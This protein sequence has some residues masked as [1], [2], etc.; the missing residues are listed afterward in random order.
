MRRVPAGDLSGFPARFP[1][2]EGGDRNAH[3]MIRA[4][5]IAA[6]VVS[7]CMLA[8]PRPAGAVACAGANR[9]ASAMSRAAVARALRCVVAAERAQHGLPAW[10][11]NRRLARAAR[12][13]ARDMVRRRYFGHASPG[14]EN[15]LR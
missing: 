4:G 15:V 3:T 10:Q 5:T 8:A 11:P 13:H 12:G 2:R 1:P 7:A 14:G 6:L 9:P